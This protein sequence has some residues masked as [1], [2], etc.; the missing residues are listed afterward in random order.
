MHACMG[1]MHACAAAARVAAK[2][3][4]GMAGQLPHLAGDPW[5]AS[6]ALAPHVSETEK[7][8]QNG[9]H[10]GAWQ[11]ALGVLL[12]AQVVSGARRRG[13]TEPDPRDDLSGGWMAARVPTALCALRRLRLRLMLAPA[14]RAGARSLV[15]AAAAVLPPSPSCNPGLC[16]EALAL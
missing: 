3:G 13:Y 5:Q 15:T 14:L 12:P 10:G 9:T 1:F 2:C 4:D 7:G 8:S 11:P 6:T 16:R